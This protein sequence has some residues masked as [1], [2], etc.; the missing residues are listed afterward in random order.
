MH[1]EELERLRDTYFD[2]FGWLSDEIV[3]QLVSMPEYDLVRRR[4]GKC[5]HTGYHT[6]VD[7]NGR[8]CATKCECART[9]EKPKDKESY[10]KNVRRSSG[11]NWG[12]MKGTG[13]FVLKKPANTP[14][15]QEWKP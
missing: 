2:A 11:K 8:N 9:L 5:R 12:A 4:C 13:T 1:V 14:D 6:W 3:E 7:A 15:V 10:Q